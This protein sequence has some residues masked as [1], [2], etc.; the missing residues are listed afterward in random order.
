MVARD[1]VNLT[2]HGN[3]GIVLP[4]RR[5][6][7]EAITSYGRALTLSPGFCQCA[8]PNRGSPVAEK[9]RL[10]GA[11]GNEEGVRR[12]RRAIGLPMAWHALGKEAE[13]DAALAELIAQIREGLA[14]NIAGVLAFRGEADR[15]F[16]WLDKAVT[17]HDGGLSEI[18]TQPQFA[19]PPQRPALGERSLHRIGKAPEPTGG[20]QVRR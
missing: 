3:L 17:Y 12:F 8:V 1:P 18:V 10:Q 19:N 9:C 14:Y 16:E 13:S 6:P 7:D 11:C 5:P 2:G 20:D 4:K 15:A